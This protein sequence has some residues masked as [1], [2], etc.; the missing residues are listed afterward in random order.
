LL[1]LRVAHHWDKLEIS[2]YDIP[3]GIIWSFVAL[4]EEHMAD[5]GN[6]GKKP[7]RDKGDTSGA[8]SVSLQL[9]VAPPNGVTTVA[10]MRDEFIRIS[11]QTPRSE[12]AKQA[13]LAS[14]LHVL[15]THPQFSLE[16]RASLVAQFSSSLKKT[17]P[18]KTR[19]PIPGGVGYGFFYEDA[20]KTNFT[21]GTG[22]C[23]DV[24]C[25]T[26][27]GG[28][29]NSYLYLTATN[30]S[31]LGVEALVAYNG[32][33]QTSFEVFDW[34]RYPATPWQTNIPFATLTGYLRT[35][36]AH[37]HSYKAL[38]LTN[39][40]F[41]DGSGLWHNQ[42]ILWNDGAARW[43][44]VYDYQYSATL[45]QQQAAF[46]G[47]W[48]PIVETFQPSYSGTEPMGALG[49]QIIGRGDQWGSWQNL[50]SPDSYLRTDNVG[51]SLI[52]LDAN[53]N[54]AVNS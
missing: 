26:P 31:S 20:F 37:G 8:A 14:K 41:T 4:K 27:P 12:E 5:K 2:A 51:F 46:Y 17:L 23:W 47:S 24:I 1:T 38:M 6:A 39:L 32:Q 18:K 44:L 36:S 45:A 29:V 40:T 30:R 11:S 49:T 52:F 22:I 15:Q 35:E 54:W 42:V 43:E 7:A 21:A 25:P 50:G 28:N 10:D 33:N 53:Y 34:A 3:R 16:A 9:L 13:F 19:R 48:G